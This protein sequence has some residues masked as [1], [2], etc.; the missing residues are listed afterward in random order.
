MISHTKMDTASRDFFH[1]YW[2]CCSS[3]CSFCSKMNK[4]NIFLNLLCPTCKDD[5]LFR[6]LKSTQMLRAILSQQLLPKASRTE[7]KQKSWN[8]VSKHVNSHNST[9]FRASHLSY[10][11][12]IQLFPFR[13]TFI[14]IGERTFS[15]CHRFVRKAFCSHWQPFHNFLSNIN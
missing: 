14:I 7:N 2:C 10:S 9:A 1:S 3:A 8:G 15:W 12:I 5:K 11:F 13:E 4:I 6:V